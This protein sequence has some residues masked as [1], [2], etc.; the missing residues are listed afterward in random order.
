MI[1]LIYQYRAIYNFDEDQD[2]SGYY[3]FGYVETE[4]HAKA[5]CDNCKENSYNIPEYRYKPIDKINFVDPDLEREVQ[6]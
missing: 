2:E 5:M 4:G 6:I 3:V 1:Y